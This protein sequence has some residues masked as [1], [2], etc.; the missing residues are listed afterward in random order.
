[1]NI[2]IV[3]QPYW[4]DHVA[5]AQILQDMAEGLV[6]K[7]HQISV[8]CSAYSYDGQ[9]S[10]LKEPNERNSVKIVRVKPIRIGKNNFTVL[11]LFGFLS[12]YWV[13]FIKVL[14]IK[15]IGF[16]LINAR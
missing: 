13:A 9:K 2:L 8:L 12:F 6:K 3:N 4:P 7:G 16:E 1:M 14:F 15:D 11:R 10:F 5:T